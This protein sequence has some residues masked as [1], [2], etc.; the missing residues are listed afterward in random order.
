MITLC[1]LAIVMKSSSVVNAHIFQLWVRWHCLHLLLPLHA[2][3]VI[4]FL[5]VWQIVLDE[6]I[7]LCIDYH[8][9]LKR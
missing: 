2:N 4:F 3:F 9:S 5:C 1:A 7:M 8:Q 6:F